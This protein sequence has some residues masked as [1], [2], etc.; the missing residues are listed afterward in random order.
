MPGEGPYPTEYMIKSTEHPPPLNENAP[1]LRLTEN[2]QFVPLHG[3]GE[4][5]DPIYELFNSVHQP[6]PGSIVE[7]I[8]S[9][10]NYQLSD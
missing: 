6:R 3:D 4:K 10:C 7:L 5:T 8:Y 1:R 2:Y 9:L